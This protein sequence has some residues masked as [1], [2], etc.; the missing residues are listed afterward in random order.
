M[1]AK[2]PRELLDSK[3]D[4]LALAL[5]ATAPPSGVERGH[6]RRAYHSNT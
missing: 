3:I 6:H 1:M 2:L 5:P 4:A